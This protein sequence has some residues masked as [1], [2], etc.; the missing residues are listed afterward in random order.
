MLRRTLLLVAAAAMA[1]LP[2]AWADGLLPGVTQDS[3]SAVGSF[4][5]DCRVCHDT[6]VPDQH[7]ALYGMPILQ[8][9]AVPY[10]DADG[11]GA[12]DSEYG[13]LNCHDTSLSVTRDCVAC[14]SS[15]VGTV[16]DR[17]GPSESPVTI[18]PVVGGDLVLSWDP[19]CEPSDTDYAVYE[20]PLEDFGDPAPV[21]CS[22]EGAT[23]VT[24]TA[25]AEDAYY[26]VV[27][28]NHW[29]EGSYGADGNGIQRPASTSACLLQ[30]IGCP[31]P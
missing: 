19:S 28:R 21:V 11:D 27:A 30:S 13:C 6:D 15:P 9:S 26:L 2:P 20:G 29:S 25:P 14:H 16:P 1:L 23:T 3:S 4:E 10:P 17:T 18:A 22:T 31:W 12:L 8:E 5:A 24:V 7:H